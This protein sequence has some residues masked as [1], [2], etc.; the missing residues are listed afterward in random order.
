MTVSYLTRPAQLPQ[1]FVSMTALGSVRAAMRREPDRKAIVFGDRT[2]TYRELVARS[3]RLRDAALTTLGLA[4]GDHVAIVARNCLEYMEVALGLPDAGVAVATVNP[5]FAAGEIRAIVENAEARVVFV[6]PLT[7]A[8]VRSAGFAPDVRIVEFGAEYEALLDG[9]GTPAEL[10]VVEEWDIW[11][12]PY[13]S[14]TT[15]MPKGVLLSHRSRLLFGL[16]SAAEYGCFG[17]DDSFLV[18]TPMAFGGGLAYPLASLAAGG[19][20][21]ITDKFEPET[22]LRKLKTGAFTGIFMVPTHFQMI[23]ELPP[24]V[25]DQYR[26]PPLRALISNAA[27]LPQALKEKIVPYFGD[28]VLHELYSATEMGVVC[29]LRPQFQLQKERCVGTP[30]PHARIAIRREDGSECDI[31]E[32]GELWVS[33]PTLFNG[34]WK[35]PEETAKAIRDGW[36]TVG[37]LA[38][39]DADGFFYIVDRK[40]DMIITGGVNVYPREIEEVLLRHPD[41]AEVAVIGVPDERWGERLLT[42]AVPRGNATLTADD[43]ARFLDGKL[44]TFK[45]PRELEIIDALPRNANG[46]VLKTELRVRVVAVPV[47]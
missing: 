25:L 26:L 28:K 9:A 29:N 34:Y 17:P 43:L 18:I 3:E 16:V 11:T 2:R 33:S 7:A 35:R 27:P 31:D 37:D 13:T 23:F 45:I 5:R 30:E 15:G 24:A 21:E 41:I 4:K 38:R 42:F 32:V 46:K 14:G 22:V 12:I 20:F 44:A 6:D 1:S 39:R 10:P 40:K 47:A 36:V 19:W 8:T